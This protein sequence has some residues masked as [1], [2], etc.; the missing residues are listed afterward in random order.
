[1]DKKKRWKLQ[2]L[3]CGDWRTILEADDRHILTDYANVCSDDVEMRILD[4]MEE[5][6]NKRDRRH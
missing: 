4:T 5:E 3:W 1:M 6:V 2:I